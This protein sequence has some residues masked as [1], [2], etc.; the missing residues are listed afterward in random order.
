[1][2]KLQLFVGLLL[3]SNLLYCQTDSTRNDDEWNLPIMIVEKMPEFVGGFE[4]MMRYINTHA[5]YTK[6]AIKEGIEGKVFISFWVMKDG[7]LTNPAI[8]RGLQHDLDSIGLSLVKNMPKWNPA[9]QS[10]LPIAVEFTLPINFSL[11]GKSAN[12]N[13][14]PTKYWQTKGKR[15]FEAVCRK[16]LQKGQRE[17]DCWYNFIISN[18]NSLRIDDL[19]LKAMFEKHICDKM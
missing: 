5:L 10:G 19:D 17:C 2:K 14:R 16:Q 8:V 9:T 7:T 13:P 3:I 4:A 15:Q 11:A 18:Y 12:N 1:M 6:Q